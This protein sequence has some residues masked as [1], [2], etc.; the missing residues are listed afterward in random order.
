MDWV[1]GFLAGVCIYLFVRC[2]QLENKI[3]NTESKMRQEFR[4]TFVNELRNIMVKLCD[5]IHDP[6][7]GYVD[8]M[9][10]I[11][12]TQKEKHDNTL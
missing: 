6:S 7:T 11:D 2:I 4:D 10:I 8:R 1:I 5:H 12:Q 3:E 9:S